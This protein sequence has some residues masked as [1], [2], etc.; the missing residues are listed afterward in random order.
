ML[1]TWISFLIKHLQR[2]LSILNPAFFTFMCTSLLLLPSLCWHIAAFC[3]ALPPPVNQWNSEQWRESILR[4]RAWRLTHKKLL[5]STT[6][7][8]KL[9]RVPL[10]FSSVKLAH[11]YIST[12]YL[13]YNVCIFKSF[14]Q[15]KVQT[16]A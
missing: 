11:M 5:N 14:Y 1:N 12:L 15:H 4:S 2:Y 13:A 7:G 16:I 9:N 6:T 3:G 8:Q 10:R